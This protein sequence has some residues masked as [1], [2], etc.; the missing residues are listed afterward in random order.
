LFPWTLRSRLRSAVQA[1]FTGIENLKS[2]N[3]Q[4]F[5]DLYNEYFNPL[6]RSC[7]FR[8]FTR[9]Q[10]FFD[11]ILQECRNSEFSFEQLFWLQHDLFSIGFSIMEKVFPKAR[12]YH[13]HTSG[14]AGVAG[15]IAA[16]QNQARFMLS[17][18][19]L[20]LRD[21]N[22]CFD[23]QDPGSDTRR[24]QT[25]SWKTWFRL[26]GKITY[27][28]CHYVTYL[29]KEIA[30][31]ATQFGSHPEKRRIIPNGVNFERFAPA[32]M[33]QKQRRLQRL[34]NGCHH[35]WNLTFLGRIVAVKGVLDLI[36]AIHRLK[37]EST[38]SF[39]V[40][41]MGP[42]DED[43][44]YFEL[45]QK[46]IRTLELQTEISFCGV[47]EVVKALASTDILLLTSHSEALPLV[48]LEAMAAGVPVLGT[49]VGAMKYIVKE[50]LRSPDS[51]ELLGPAGLLVPPGQPELFKMALAELMNQSSGLTLYSENGPKR[52][53]HT[54]AEEK[55][56]A[57]Y[58]QIYEELLRST[59][60]HLAQ[61]TESINYNKGC[62]S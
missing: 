51:T 2:K 31:E 7:D 49:N 55:I 20:Y 46:R 41:L 42:T 30:E 24:L 59:P 1:L 9:H 5:F 48:V 43:P 60:S 6:T 56:M 21:V 50:G 19:S 54:F 38:F 47:Q 40:N 26:M 18:H 25:E 53:Q 15:A 61:Q 62:A 44:E 16:N 12:L 33:A 22:H 4:I 17:E 36:E 29:F 11:F 10:D 57:Q 34:A 27:N 39:H 8:S 23:Q 28:Q 14:Y 35:R 3:E 58:T 13:S 37:A 32:R 45:C 52:V